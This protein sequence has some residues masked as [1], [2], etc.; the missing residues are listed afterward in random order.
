MPKTTPL[1]DADI[2]AL[3]IAAK[4]GDKEAFAEIYDH[5]FD[6][7]FRYVYFRVKPEEVD[8][9]VET[10]FIKSWVKLEKYEKRDVSFGAWLFRIAHNAVIDYRR[11]HRSILPIDP[12][13][14]DESVGAA[15]ERQTERAMMA[16]EVRAAVDELKEPYKQ[17][18]TLK[19]LIGISNAEIAEIL[20]QTE[21][22]VRV[23]QFRA[24][25]EL[26]EK[27]KERGL[28]PEFLA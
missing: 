7:I 8:D 27:L 16:Q 23:L 5:Y 12:R 15:P 2:D 24:L 18:V 22:N 4:E 9:I 1:S 26:K 13:T 28:Q 3:V 10:V 17:V 21:G 11:A 19:F 6:Q 14:K 20:G 25:K